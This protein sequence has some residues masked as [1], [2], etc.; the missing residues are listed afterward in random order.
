MTENI[1][2]TS[3]GAT[4]LTFLRPENKDKNRNSFRKISHRGTELTEDTKKN[5]N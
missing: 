2:K 4:A 1:K 5:R 3:R